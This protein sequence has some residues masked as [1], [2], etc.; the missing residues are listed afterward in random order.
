MCEWKRSIYIYIY[1]YIY[2]HHRWVI[3]KDVDINGESLAEE[4][5]NENNNVCISNKQ[6]R[7]DSMLQHNLS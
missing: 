4:Y 7:M 6:G 5:H 2:D 1:I 3:N